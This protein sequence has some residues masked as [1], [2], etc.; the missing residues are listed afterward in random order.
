[1][2]VILGR[3]AERYLFETVLTGTLI[4]AVKTAERRLLTTPNSMSKVGGADDD[5]RNCPLLFFATDTVGSRTQTRLVGKQFYGVLCPRITIVVLATVPWNCVTAG[6]NTV[7][8][9]I[10]HVAHARTRSKE[11]IGLV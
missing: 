11:G 6:V 9:T 1:M 10:H 5:G 2:H 4:D 7:S 8:P 3:N